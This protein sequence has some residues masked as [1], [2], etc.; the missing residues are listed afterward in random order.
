MEQA[1]LEV[2][3]KRPLPAFFLNGNDGTAPDEPAGFDRSLSDYIKLGIKYRWLIAGV[4][5]VTVSLTL[6]YSLLATPLYTANATLKIGTYSPLLPGASIESLQREQTMEQDY[7]NTQVEI[8]SSLSLA[9]KVYSQ[10]SI[11]EE[12]SRYLGRQ[13]G[14]FSVFRPFFSS[15][16]S[17]KTPSV[18]TAYHQSISKLKQYKGLLTITP[19]RRTSLVK[20]SVTMSDPA[21]AAKVANLHAKEYIELTRA[22]RQKSALDNLIFLQ[23]QAQELAD[24][25]ALLEREMA[26]YAEG[27]AIVS[28]TKDENIVVKQMSELNDLLTAATAKRIQ[29]ETTYNEAKAGSGLK[30]TAYDDESIQRLR[31]TL[32][33]AEAEFALLSEKFTPSYPRMVQLKA[34]IDTLKENLTA[35][36]AEVIK[37]L[38][39]K[40]KAD[41]ES[42]KSLRAQ[43]ETQKSAAFDLSRR[44]V[45]YNIMKREY[46]SLKDLYQAVLRQLKEA[47]LSAQGSGTNISIAE[48]AA[49]P[50]EHSSPQ[51]TLNLLLALCLSPMLGCALALAAESLDNTIK[52]P[53]EAQSILQLPTLGI[54]P[55]FSLAYDE[56]GLKK[57][58]A[59]RTDSNKPGLPP[60]KID[61]SIISL[62]NALQDE[63][64]TITS[65]R[66][67]A[68]EAFRTIRT[69][70][71]L[72]SADNPP[73]VILVTSGQ[74]SEGKTTLTAN[75]AITL[76]Q[77]GNRTLIIDGDLRRP[78]VH[79]FFAVGDTL[80]G[81]VDYL[82]GQRTLVEVVRRSPVD[83]LFVIAAGLTPPNPSELLGSR[84]L[85]CLLRD[86]KSQFD[87]IL[88]DAPPVL[89]VT[90]AVLLSRSVDGVVVVVRGQE[91][92]HQIARDAVKRLKQVGARILGIV[93]NDVDLRSGDY[94]Y[95]RRGYHSYYR[96]ERRDRKQA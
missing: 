87:F 95:Y 37:G 2:A 39:A 59:A 6:L 94:Y 5:G 85:S 55:M 40:Y 86:L 65:P 42:E 89:P 15:F 22:D 52:T 13:T 48:P 47:Q 11:A 44:E 79:K 4:V 76:A 56:Q 91:T 63:L 8:L 67:M 3:A 23:G 72:S 49:V 61:P 60:K 43:L 71:I 12:L 33:E 90:D 62:D 70:V 53:E 57:I 82:T 9:D 78:A 73:R 80:P 92:T 69:S 26:S 35:Q 30:S 41:L 64:V 18:E 96:D 29:S 31:V 24:K 10:S 77:S 66:S 45:Q 17:S 27:N 58:S 84:K 50:T 68:S 75:L 34:R 7:L 14:L 51:R 74:K 1:K 38:E 81:I 93:L 20:V 36:R 83:R 19:I 21:L 16:G 25:I 32:K 54:V 88:V 46:D 28:V